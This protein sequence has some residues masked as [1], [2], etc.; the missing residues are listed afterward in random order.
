[1]GTNKRI[2][3]EIYNPE[4]LWEIIQGMVYE[5]ISNNDFENLITR[6][7]TM[8]SHKTYKDMVDKFMNSEAYEQYKETI[9]G[10]LN[11]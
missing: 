6:L 8:L 9:E 5:A 7:L 1:M 11:G 10:E 2:F 3:N 4:F